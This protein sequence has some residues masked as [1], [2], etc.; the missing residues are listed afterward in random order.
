MQ[1]SHFERLIR[2]N[3]A[4]LQ[5]IRSTYFPLIS[6]GLITGYNL[7]LAPPPKVDSTALIYSHSDLKP[8]DQHFQELKDLFRRAGIPLDKRIL[9][10]SRLVGRSSVCEREATYLTN[11]DWKTSDRYKYFARNGRELR[12]EETKIREDPVIKEGLEYDIFLKV[13][14]ETELRKLIDLFKTRAS[15]FKLD[16]YGKIIIEEDPLSNDLAIFGAW[17]IPLL[18]YLSSNNKKPRNLRDFMGVN[19]IEVSDKLGASEVNLSTLVKSK[20]TELKRKLDR[21]GIKFNICKRY[22]LR[23]FVDDYIDAIK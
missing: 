9:I 22:A 15:K 8:D 3:E 16:R 4:D 5:R 1:E 23:T 2:E 20:T 18:T 12:P 13:T 10:N 14:S 17:E 19:Q 21:R 7:H 6:E 11:P